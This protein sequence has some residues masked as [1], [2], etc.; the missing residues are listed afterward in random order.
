VRRGQ[1]RI[2]RPV[3]AAGSDEH[4]PAGHVVMLDERITAGLGRS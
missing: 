3:V 4:A 1:R 2:A